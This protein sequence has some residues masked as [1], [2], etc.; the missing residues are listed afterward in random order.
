MIG[1]ALLDALAVMEVV[2]PVHG[3]PFTVAEVVNPEAAVIVQ[4]V[5]VTQ[6]L[7][8]AAVTVYVCG[9]KAENKPVVFVEGPE[10]LMVY[11]FVPVPPDA[12]T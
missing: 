5:V 1:N 3:V 9:A 11:V 10:G 2:P 7:T 8:S 12:E 4:A 6:P